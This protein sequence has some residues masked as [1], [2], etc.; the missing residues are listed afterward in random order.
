[1]SDEQ[2]SHGPQYILS[3]SGLSGFAIIATLIARIPDEAGI[4]HRLNEY[5][6]PDGHLL[7]EYTSQ[8]IG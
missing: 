1:M 7:G 5:P 8:C 3:E 2:N 4:S 6:H